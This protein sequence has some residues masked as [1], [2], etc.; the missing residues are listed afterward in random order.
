M[1][2]SHPAAPHFLSILPI[3]I[4]VA[5]EEISHTDKMNSKTSDNIYLHMHVPELPRIEGIIYPELG[6]RP[7]ILTLSNLILRHKVP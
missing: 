7:I 5:S 4:D 3:D 2:V 1:P 6:Q